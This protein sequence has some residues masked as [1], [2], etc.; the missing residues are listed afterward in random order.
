MAGRVGP[1]RR[2]VA[3][4]GEPADSGRT[5]EADIGG[6]G[7]LTWSGSGPAPTAGLLTKV[8]R[9][10]ALAQHGRDVEQSL[11]RERIG[12]LLLLV[13]DRLANPLA[14][15][16]M[17][18]E[19][20]ISENSLVVSAWPA[21]AA[22]L[23]AL[24]LSDSLIGEAPGIALAITE[25]SAR[26]VTV[27]QI[28][29]LPCGYSHSAELGSLARATA[30]ARAALELARRRGGAVG[31][32]SLTS[33]EGLLEQQ[34]IERL[35]PFIDQLITPLLAAD[36]QHGTNQVQTLR[37]FLRLD[38]SLQSTARSEFLHVNTVR[39][40][41]ERIRHLTGRDPLVFADRA[42]LAI[43]LWAYDRRQAHPGG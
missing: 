36:G 2:T 14:V 16:P 12:Q 24:H 1:G 27:A 40:R 42:A 25:S 23:L 41:L 38:G 13:G 5:V 33:L 34:P 9:V 37:T 7:R 18:A 26:V 19:S 28:L 39:H 22:P 30:E 6:G 43:A 20:G 8:G 11:T 31:P 29:T 21:G 10:L 3:A 15:R 32:D 17:L 4:A 35:M